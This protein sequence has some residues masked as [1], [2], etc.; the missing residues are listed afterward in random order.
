MPL[1][2]WICE[3]MAWSDGAARA[4]QN[5]EGLEVWVLL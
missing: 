2:V 5:Y 3:S 4:L 1:R